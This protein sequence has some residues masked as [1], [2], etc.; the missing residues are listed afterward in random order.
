MENRNNSL[1]K[2]GIIGLAG[3][4]VLGWVRE[5]EKH[6][7]SQD[8]AHAISSTDS[9]QPRTTFSAPVN[10]P[11]FDEAATHP[12]VT[13]ADDS[14]RTTQELNSSKST[15]SLQPAPR[16]RIQRR[17]AKARKEDSSVVRTQGQP[18]DSGRH[19]RAES[20]GR[21][22]AT[23]SSETR[24]ER[25]ETRPVLESAD[26]TTER[27]VRDSEPSPHE[28]TADYGGQTQPVVRAKDRSTARSAAIIV[29]TAAAG[30]A[31]GGASGGGKG[32]TI[33]AISGAAGGY[34]YDRVTRRKGIPDPPAIPDRDSADRSDTEQ[35]ENDHGDDPAPSLARRF[36]TPSFIGR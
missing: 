15:G 4:E 3:V 9:A 32:A 14:R 23:R 2:Y 12:A 7:F 16:G 33:G 13:H 6:Q 24:I 8:S 18:G 27:S 11:G 29:G 21:G 22:T 36:G 34:V 28:R 19:G 20:A 26:R 10:V 30:A 31:I 35:Y 5:P 25:D 1:G 17:S